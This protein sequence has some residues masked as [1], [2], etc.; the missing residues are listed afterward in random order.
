VIA[1]KQ[2]KSKISSNMELKVLKSEGQ[3]LFYQNK[4]F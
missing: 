4:T 3:I 1:Q 2:A